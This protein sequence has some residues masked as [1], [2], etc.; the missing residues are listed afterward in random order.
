[1]HPNDGNVER[2]AYGMG[3]RGAHEK[4]SCKAG[5]FRY[6]DC[7]DVFFGNACFFKNLIG[8][9]QHAANMIA[10][11]KFGHHAAVG[12]VHVDLSVN[13]VRKKPL[14]AVDQGYSSFV[15]R[16]LNAKDFH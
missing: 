6:G 1:M 9:N 8:K 2:V 10:A 12:A 14:F 15:A 3:N 5:A 7:I 16:T 13:G 11:G 4:R